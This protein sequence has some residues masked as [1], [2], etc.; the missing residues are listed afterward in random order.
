MARYAAHC[1]ICM[2]NIRNLSKA[3]KP[4]WCNHWFHKKC[5]W[6]WFNRHRSY[7]TCCVCRR[8][9]DHVVGEDNKIVNIPISPQLRMRVIRRFV[10][11]TEVEL[12]FLGVAKRDIFETFVDVGGDAMDTWFELASQHEQVDSA[13]K[14]NIWE[15]SRNLL[16]CKHILNYQHPSDERIW[17]RLTRYYSIF[18]D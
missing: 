1:C 18:R 8:Y 13:Y 10:R 17:T 9:V 4:R 5:W 15:P 3:C 7:P 12:D 14:W 6:E 2:T 11:L 16:V